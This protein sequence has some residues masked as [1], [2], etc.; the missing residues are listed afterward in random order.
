MSNPSV[1]VVIPTLDEES[2]IVDCLDAIGARAHVERV[3]SDGGSRDRTLELVSALP[4][5][6]VV[7][8]PP[9]RGGQLRRGAAATSGDVLLF[10]HA[11]CRLPRG[12]WEAVCGALADPAVSLTCFRL[13]TAPTDASPVG[14]A[15]RAWLRLLDLRSFVGAL[16]YGDQGFAVRRTTYDAIGGFRDIP[17]LEDVEFARAA[18]ALGRL[19]VLPLEIRTSARRVARQPVRTRLM[20]A[21]FPWLYRMGVS[22]GRLASWYGNVR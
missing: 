12:W 13:H 6:T 7:S 10:L 16:P 8:G 19:E 9:G 17:L 21:T 20:T 22:P 11:D 4:G 1:S 2:T 14:C 15:G 3:V 5:V 18:R